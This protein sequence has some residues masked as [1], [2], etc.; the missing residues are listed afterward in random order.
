MP[1][2]GVHIRYP[3]DEEAADESWLEAAV[4]RYGGQLAQAVFL[5]NPLQR[6][7]SFPDHQKAQSFVSGLVE[8]ERW[9]ACLQGKGCPGW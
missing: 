9:H 5:S 4:S 2:C 8:T 6:L 1:E 7:A 3:H